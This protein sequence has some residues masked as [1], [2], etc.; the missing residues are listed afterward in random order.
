M[1]LENMSLNE[2]HIK[3]VVTITNRQLD[4]SYEYLLSCKHMHFVIHINKT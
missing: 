1:Q 2:I 4:I 3:S